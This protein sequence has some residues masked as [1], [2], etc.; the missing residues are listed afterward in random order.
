ML[1]NGCNSKAKN[2][3]VYF[4]DSYIMGGLSSPYYGLI[5]DE[6]FVEVNDEN[7]Q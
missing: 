6:L 2:K 1:L 4:P 7:Q 5:F 3:I